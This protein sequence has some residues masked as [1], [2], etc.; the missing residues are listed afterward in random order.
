M[1]NFMFCNPM[2]N[3]FEFGDIILATVLIFRPQTKQTK[4]YLFTLKCLGGC[5]FGGGCKRRGAK[6][7]RKLRGRVGVEGKEDVFSS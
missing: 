6:R 3:P 5:G 1:K 2:K 4:P 7:R